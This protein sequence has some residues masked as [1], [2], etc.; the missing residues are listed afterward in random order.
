[1]ISV[2]TSFD[3]SKFDPPNYLIETDAVRFPRS[4]DCRN[5]KYVSLRINHPENS[6]SKGFGKIVNATLS[7]RNLPTDNN[8]DLTNYDSRITESPFTILRRMKSRG[9]INT[10]DD[11]IRILRII[12]L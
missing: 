8:A 10:N 1:M 6:T 7:Y 12:K 2:E 11:S 4:F 3:Q 9:N 5:F